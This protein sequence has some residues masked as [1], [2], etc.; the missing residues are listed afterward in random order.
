MC[1]GWRCHSS[2]IF[3]ILLFTK[4][5]KNVS[6][7]LNQTKTQITH[8]V[9]QPFQ[10]WCLLTIFSW[11]FSSAYVQT[12]TKK[13]FLGD[14]SKTLLL[15]SR[16]LKNTKEQRAFPLL[17]IPLSS[18][19]DGIMVIKSLQEPWMTGL[20]GEIPFGTLIDGIMV[21]AARNAEW[22]EDNS[23]TQPWIRG[24]FQRNSIH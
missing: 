19:I 17:K 20:W 10:D 23:G 9:F 16:Y 4:P 12:L 2:L 13:F 5:N 7:W 6:G 14:L 15:G 22:S 8:N 18:L 11:S 3:L 21:V 1:V 24:C